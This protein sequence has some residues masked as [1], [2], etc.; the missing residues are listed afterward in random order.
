MSFVI[1]TSRI[2]FDGM[3]I[4]KVATVIFDRSQIYKDIT[5]R[6]YLPL[7]KEF[8]EWAIKR[9]IFRADQVSYVVVEDYAKALIR[10]MNNGV[11]GS[12]SV[13]SKIAC[14]N[15]IMAVVYEK[16]RLPKWISISC[17]ALGLP[18]RN[19]KRLSAPD[20]LERTVY[21]SR[22]SNLPS[23]ARPH[24]I[25]VVEMCR[26]FGFTAA[27]AAR[28]DAKTDWRLVKRNF[29]IG[30]PCYVRAW[31]GDKGSHRRR[32]VLRNAE[33]YA[34]L[35]RCAKAQGNRKQLM[36][37]GVSLDKWREE[38]MRPSVKIMGG[39]I[40]LRVAYACERFRE[41]A[42][43]SPPCAGGKATDKVHD[44]A[45]RSALCS[46]LGLRNISSIISSIG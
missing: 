7:W 9:N 32:V 2:K 26:E 29:H 12:H 45:V 35:Q 33:Q 42:G 41:L 30:E 38:F 40:D 34:V 6:T 24:E 31:D 1:S 14:V 25:A 39:L 19:T 43:Y 21:Q 15:S 4:D 27:E 13:Q 46:E 28:F 17:R 8:S 23:I 36:D 18:P 37:D 16:R 22:L 44:D 5:K 10:Q 20:T 3:D 11:L